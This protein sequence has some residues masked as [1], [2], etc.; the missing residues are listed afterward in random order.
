MRG[1]APPPHY[2]GVENQGTNFSIEVSAIRSSTGASITDA[3]CHIS[4]LRRAF[5]AETGLLRQRLQ[6]LEATG[7]PAGWRVTRRTKRWF[8]SGLA[9]ISA[10][11]FAAGYLVSLRQ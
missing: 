10:S 1:F 9:L 3:I 7:K 5:T 11:A 8:W 6:T 2:I 4:R